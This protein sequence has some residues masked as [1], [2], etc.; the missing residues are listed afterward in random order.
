MKK[1][2]TEGK[3]AFDKPVALASGLDSKAD[4]RDRAISFPG[5]DPT[6]AHELTLALELSGNARA[7]VERAMFVRPADGKGTA[8]GDFCDAFSLDN[9]SLALV[10]GDISG[11]DPYAAGN[12]H[13]VRA[14]LRL[15][16]YGDPDPANALASLNTSLCKLAPD[17]AG[18]IA[19]FVCMSIAVIQP[20]TETGVFA[21][22]GSKPPMIVSTTAMHRSVRVG[23]PPLGIFK[24]TQFSAARLPISS[25]DVLI[26]GTN[27][28]FNAGGPYRPLGSERLLK[29]TNGLVPLHSLAMIGQMLMDEIESFALGN[30]RDDCA[31]LLAR[32]I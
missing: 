7:R 31:L 9:G 21:C 3:C 22:A 12:V 2:L 28:I 5:T 20:Q 16:L 27:G 14:T 30:I 25:S 18:E 13:E 29:W 24:E 17:N 11:R 6:L 8:C 23:G 26:M 19:P 10:V 15:A 4:G 1:S 32:L